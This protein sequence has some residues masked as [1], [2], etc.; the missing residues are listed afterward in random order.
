MSTRQRMDSEEPDSDLSSLLGQQDPRYPPL[1]PPQQHRYH[2]AHDPRYSSDADASSDFSS[3]SEMDMH[4]D[5]LAGDY[6]DQEL[7]L[8]GRWDLAAHWHLGD[9]SEGV[10]GDADDDDDEERDIDTDLSEG[11]GPS[12]SILLDLSRVH[13]ILASIPSTAAVSRTRPPTRP[14]E[15]TPTLALRN[16]EPDSHSSAGEDVLARETP[17]IRHN[18]PSTVSP[19]ERTVR[20]SR[21]AAL[22]HTPE[23]TTDT[24]LP[25]VPDPSTAAHAAGQDDVHPDNYNGDMDDSQ[26]DGETRQVPLPPMAAHNGA[27]MSAGSGRYGRTHG[28]GGPFGTTTALELR[29]HFGIHGPRSSDLAARTGGH[30]YS[31]LQQPLSP[32]LGRYDRRSHIHTAA[33]M[34]SSRHGLSSSSSARRHLSPY[35]TALAQHQH[36]ISSSRSSFSSSPSSSA[37]SSRMPSPGLDWTSSALKS[38][39]GDEPSETTFVRAAPGNEAGYQG[40][41]YDGLVEAIAPTG[42]AA[43]ASARDSTASSGRHH[44]VISS[45]ISSLPSFASSVFTPRGDGADGQGPL[46]TNKAHRSNHP[47][48]QCCFL[49]PGQKFH[50]TQNLKTLTSSLSGMRCRQTEEWDVKVTISAVDYRSSTVYGLMEAMDVPMSASSVVT[51][52]EGE[53]IDFENHTFW[54]RKWTAKARTDLEHW[55]RLEAFNGIDEKYIIRGAKTGKFRGHIDQK[56][57]FMRWKEKHF[58]NASEHTGGL[59]IAGFYYLSMRRSDGFVEGYYHDQQSTPFQH[60][61]LNP[62]FEAGGFS[63]PIF[64]LA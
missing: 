1:P 47:R 58:V 24:A 30:R 25:P 64:E 10:E 51:F 21:D 54:T 39:D 9:Y 11:P 14:G 35:W 63:S 38:P 15:P 8:G 56:Y 33:A 7:P 48:R 43:A 59:T 34:L 60:L 16:G 45:S 61:T 13:D 29:H 50:G 3:L 32:S 26:G 49:Q 4:R 27:Y 6:S 12:G 41:T 40:E 57:I 22:P 55:K 53:I 28:T 19:S 37:S 44:R 20:F 52:W 62:T 36:P 23:L 2:A 31:T 42:S 17:S 46:G 5:M 18:H